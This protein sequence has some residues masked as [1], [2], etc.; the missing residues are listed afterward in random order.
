MNSTRSLKSNPG[1]TGRM[2][3]NLG[4]MKFDGSS[5]RPSSPLTNVNR[6]SHFR[7]PNNDEQ[8]SI[9]PVKGFSEDDRRYHKTVFDRCVDSPNGHLITNR[10]KF[11][12]GK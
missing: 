10:E 12:Q 9:S 2:S 5:N 4:A 8:F 3:P 11:G 6:L 7:K 1:S